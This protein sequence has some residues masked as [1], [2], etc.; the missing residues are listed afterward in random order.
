[1][2]L[3]ISPFPITN[4]EVL[5]LVADRKGFLVVQIHVQVAHVKGVMILQTAMVPQFQ[6]SVIIN[7]EDVDD[8]NRNQLGFN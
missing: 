6:Q 2:R 5:E 4:L 7:N 1:M 3:I 8:V